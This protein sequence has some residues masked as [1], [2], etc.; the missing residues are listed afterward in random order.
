MVDGVLVFTGLVDK[1]RVYFTH[2]LWNE[3]YDDLTKRIELV[4]RGLGLLRQPDPKDGQSMKLRVIEQ[5]K[6]WVIAEPG[7]LT[8][9]KPEDY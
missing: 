3:G 1:D 5:D 8:Y 7:K 9:L 2:S 6:V 4:N